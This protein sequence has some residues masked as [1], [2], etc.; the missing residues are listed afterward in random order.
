[1]TNQNSTLQGAIA[2]RLLRR[3]QVEQAIGLSRSTIYAR[4]DK[5]SP[6]YDP[7]FPKP[8]TLGST[9]VAWIEAEI[10]QW[11]ASRIAVSRKTAGV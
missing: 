3:K 2:H 6:H 5:H 9:S 8:I 11:I 1:M 10:Q 4:L 7:T